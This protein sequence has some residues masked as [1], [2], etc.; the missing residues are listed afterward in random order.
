M[1]FFLVTIFFLIVMVFFYHNLLIGCRGFFG[2]NIL[3]DLHGHKILPNHETFL[4]CKVLPS[5]DVL[6]NH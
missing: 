3:L 1:E 2:C 4:G 6:F 5:Y